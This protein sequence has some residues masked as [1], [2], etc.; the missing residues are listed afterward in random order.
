MCAK[1]SY[2]IYVGQRTTFKCGFTWVI[3]IK[4]GVLGFLLGSVMTEPCPQPR[5]HESCLRSLLSSYPRC[6][7]LIRRWKR[8]RRSKRRRR[9]EGEREERKNRRRRKGRK[10]KKKKREEMRREG[11][12]REEKK[13]VS[14]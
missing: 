9:G 14:Q 12:G 6:F 8:K 7:S 1:A 11:K 2:H 5:G 4:S 3:E 13:A 10:E